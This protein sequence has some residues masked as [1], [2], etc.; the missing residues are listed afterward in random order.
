MTPIKYAS[1]WQRF[2]AMWI[3]FFILLPFGVAHHFIASSSKSAALVLVIPMASLYVA[4]TIY[5]HGRSGQ[6]VGKRLMAIR[7]VQTSGERIGWRHAWLRSSVDVV[8]SVLYVIGMFIA[9]QAISDTGYY[10]VGWLKR[11]VSLYALWPPW[12]AWSS[13]AM[14]YWTWSEVVVMLFNKRRRALHDFIAGTVVVS[15]S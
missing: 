6:T 4:Y 11:N 15:E 13:N 10:G 3:D 8:F 2:G 1:F 14:D 7:V 5:Y 12:I 9:L